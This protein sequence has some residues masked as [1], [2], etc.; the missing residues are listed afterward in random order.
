[1]CWFLKLCQTWLVSSQP[2]TSD[3]CSHSI[4][5]PRKSVKINCP[6]KIPR[7]NRLSTW[8]QKC[9][10]IIFWAIF[11]IFIVE[12]FKE[13]KLEPE[14]WQ[15]AGISRINAM[16]SACLRHL[17]RVFPFPVYRFK[18]FKYVDF[19]QIFPRNFYFNYN[20]KGFIL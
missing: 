11:R 13:W 8:R 16:S 17:S 9:Q 5:Q 1:M 3:S 7:D 20:L 19:T 14:V 18:S 4:V 6:E 15:E 10:G 2:N 12:Q